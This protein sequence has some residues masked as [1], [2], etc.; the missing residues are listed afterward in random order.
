MHG[1]QLIMNFLIMP[2]F[3]LSGALFPLSSAPDFL[4]AISML[5]PLTYGVSGLRFILLGHSD[6]S[7]AVSLAVVGAFTAAFI[8]IA[9]FLFNRIEE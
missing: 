6:I 4:K 1:F 3:V 8:A 7:F 9:M 5:D 2:L